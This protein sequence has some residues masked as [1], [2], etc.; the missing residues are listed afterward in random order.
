MSRLLLQ[1]H[2][3]DVLS[4]SDCKIAKI[5]WGFVHGPCWWG[6]TVPSRLPSCTMVFLRA[7]LVKKWAPPKKMLDTALHSY[8]YKQICKGSKLTHC[9]NVNVKTV[10]GFMA[11]I[12]KMS[13]IKKWNKWLLV[14]LNL[15]ELSLVL[16][17]DGLWLIQK[18]FHAF[19]IIGNSTIPS[20]DDPGY[21]PCCRM[22]PLLDYISTVCMHYFMPGQ[23]VAID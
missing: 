8:K 4:Y 9:K 6:L 3:S 14:C 19:F 2:E 12:F 23:A 1:S 20:K 10:K 13:L 22:R 7:T 18:N 11:I 21:R 17:N 5:F 16:S 15:Y